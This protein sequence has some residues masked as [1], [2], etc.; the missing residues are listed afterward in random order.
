MGASVDLETVM[1][2]TALSH[3]AENGY[4]DVVRL[5]L[6]HGASPHL[7]DQVVYRTPLMWAGSPRLMITSMPVSVPPPQTYQRPSWLVELL[8]SLV[9]NGEPLP[10]DKMP[11]KDKPVGR[12]I[13]ATYIWIYSNENGKRAG[14]PGRVQWSAGAA[15]EDILDLLLE[16]GADL[17]T[18]SQ[19]DGTALTLAAACG[20]EPIVQALLARGASL[21]PSSSHASPI[22]GALSGGHVDVMRLLLDR[23]ARVG[24]VT[25]SKLNP[26]ADAVYKGNDTLVR[27]LLSA[28]RESELEDY[29]APFWTPMYRAARIGNIRIMEVLLEWHTSLWPTVSI[30]LADLLFTAV[31]HNREDM[32][33]FLLDAGA[34][35]NQRSI[36]PHMFADGKTHIHVAASG[37]HQG[38]MRQ[39]LAQRDLD[40]NAQDSLGWTGLTWASK[41]CNEEMIQLLLEHG[42]D[43]AFMCVKDSKPSRPTRMV[44]GT[45][46]MSPSP[47]REWLISFRPVDD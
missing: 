42:A 27:L 16:Y 46:W 20:H 39:L 43:P 8:T 2:R 30:D 23:G 21:S 5:L 34:P 26:V 6:S 19:I 22:L 4:V 32:V 11:M 3:A 12:Q 15:Y 18:T 35:V 47:R 9:K 29:P 38:I 41:N 14:L 45:S 44:C 17:E 37:G 24:S 10:R 7:Q 40:I 1:K 13:G 31:Q 28:V 36:Y 25:Q 33:A